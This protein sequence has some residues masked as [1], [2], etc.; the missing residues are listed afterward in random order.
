MHSKLEILQCFQCFIQLYLHPLS[1]LLPFVSSL[2]IS[3]FHNILNNLHQFQQ[4]HCPFRIGERSRNFWS[5]S[6]YRRTKFTSSD[7][8]FVELFGIPFLNTIILT[9]LQVPHS[10]EIIDLYEHDALIPLHLAILS[11]TQIRSL[12]LHI[13]TF[14]VMK[15]TTQRFTTHIV[16]LIIKSSHYTKCISVNTQYVSK[17]VHFSTFVSYRPVYKSLPGESTY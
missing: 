6:S 7:G 9:H 1:K 15:H 16:P 2:I 11:S 10:T 8:I 12:V 3:T 5:D 17:Y 14:H 4:E 13:I